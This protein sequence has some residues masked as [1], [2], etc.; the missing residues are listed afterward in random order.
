MRYAQGV[1]VAAL[2][3]LSAAAYASWPGSDGAYHYFLLDMS[4]NGFDL[5]GTNRSTGTRWT[6]AAS[7]D[8][9]LAVDATALRAIG[10]DISSRAHTHLDGVVVVSTRL[11]FTAEGKARETTDAWQLLAVL[12]S[13]HDGTLDAKDRCWSRLRLFVDRNGDG[14]MAPDEV[15]S[16]ETDIRDITIRVGPAPEGRTD[17]QGSNLVEG[18]FTR[19]DGA[20]RKSADV[21]FA[22]VPEGESAL[23]RR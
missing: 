3:C 15:L 7:D 10:I 17:A 5:S 8:A 2:G 22:H 6:H 9:F 19:N 4:G 21:T 1:L 13:N 11:H 14:S 16:A 20:T 18:T 23:A 12:D